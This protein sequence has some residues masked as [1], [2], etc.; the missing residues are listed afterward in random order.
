M[1]SF[2]LAMLEE[3]TDKKRFE[4]I[5]QRYRGYMCKI[6]L[7][8]TD[9]EVLAMDA[10]NDAFVAIAKNINRIPSDRGVEFERRYIRKT[11]L[12]RLS[13]AKRAEDKT[14]KDAEV[15]EV[16]ISNSD[17]GDVDDDTNELL[18]I[19]KILPNYYADTLTLYYIDEMKVAD[20]AT[21][22]GVSHYTV[23]SRIRRGVAM[24]KK[25]LENKKNYG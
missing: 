17:Y 2:Y 3:E 9:N 15:I 12:S 16:K 13:N 14:I 25:H 8:V 10:V 20:I 4:E 5:Y 21:L 24:L 23:Y 18:D 11:I 22:L 6:A 1:L 7:S 19:L